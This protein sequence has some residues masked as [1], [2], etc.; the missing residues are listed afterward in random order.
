MK[1]RELKVGD[2]FYFKS[3]PTK[4]SRRKIAFRKYEEYYHS[5]ANFVRKARGE[6][7][8]VKLNLF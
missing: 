5:D 3:S 7:D 8:V 1:F 2:V 4:E 6:S